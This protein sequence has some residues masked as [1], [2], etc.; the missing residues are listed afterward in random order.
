MRGGAH[1]EEVRRVGEARERQPAAARERAR[2]ARRA[3][4]EHQ[5]EERRDGGAEGGAREEHEHQVEQCI[6]AL[7]H[8]DHLTTSH[9]FHSHRLVQVFAHVED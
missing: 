4:A 2:E 1:L 3:A 8:S 6:I 5:E 7:E 9:E